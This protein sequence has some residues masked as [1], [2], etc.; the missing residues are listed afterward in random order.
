MFMS[1]YATEVC[2]CP[3]HFHITQINAHYV[4]SLRIRIFGKYFVINNSL[5]FVVFYLFESYE[6]KSIS[7]RMDLWEV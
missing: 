1:D 3:E 6:R 4:L 2:K 7:S 5:V